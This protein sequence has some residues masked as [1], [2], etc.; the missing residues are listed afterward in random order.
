MKI[1]IG[2]KA[3]ILLTT[4]V[5]SAC[6]NGSLAEAQSLEVTAACALVTSA[7]DSW[8]ATGQSTATETGRIG[9][10]NLEDSFNT[11]QDTLQEFISDKE[12][13]VAR[14]STKEISSSNVEPADIL[15]GIRN[16][17]N[18]I[19]NWEAVTNGMNWT[20]GQHASIDNIY[21]NAVKNSCNA[22]KNISDK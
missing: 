6:G 8:A 19:N 11:S 21:T 1:K 22:F 13:D 7:Y 9:R 14:N 20:A 2:L 3:G 15:L 5:L 12:I 17:Q 10:E 16:L 18:Y 4:L